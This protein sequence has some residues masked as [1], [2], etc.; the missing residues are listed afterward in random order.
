MLRAISTAAALL[1]V[2]A[3]SFAL[4][5][6][7][8]DAATA[9]CTV[10]KSK[11]VGGYNWSKM[12]VTR[13]CSNS[14]AYG[15]SGTAYIA[16]RSLVINYSERTTT[17]REVEK[18]T[19]HE[20]THHVEYRTTAPERARLYRYLGISNP[21]GNYFAF[22]DAYYYN[23]SMARWRQSPRE[24]LAESVV[25]CTYGTPNHTGLKLV[26]KGQCKSFLAEYRKA[27]SVAR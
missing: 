7:Q 19:V 12:P 10:I 26:P 20:L 13:Y 9:K 8:A 27:L 18:A 1:T 14:L 22:N 6:S 23:G 21:S 17:V 24:R 15:A 4:P 16:K 3:T 11:T 25:N 5:A 2:A